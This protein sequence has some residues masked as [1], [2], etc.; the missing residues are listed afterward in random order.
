MDPDT[1][2][3]V[4][5]EKWKER[6]A[7]VVT[8]LVN[9]IDLVRKGTFVPDREENE[10]TLALWNPEHWGRCRGYGSGI[11]WK[12]RFSADVGSYRSRSRNKKKNKKEELDRLS[13]LER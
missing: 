2:L 9:A 6:I 4:A 10:L 7:R 5:K 3:I 11:T 8:K 13:E 12:Q 1:G